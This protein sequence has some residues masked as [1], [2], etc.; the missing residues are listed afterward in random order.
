[1]FV[2]P[3]SAGPKTDDPQLAAAAKDI[4]HIILGKEAAGWLRMLF[5]RTTD[6]RRLA[7]YYRLEVTLR[8]PFSKITLT[9]LTSGGRVTVDAHDNSGV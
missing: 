4:H 1:M 5:R 7:E 8:P 9:S 3:L 2:R 6:S